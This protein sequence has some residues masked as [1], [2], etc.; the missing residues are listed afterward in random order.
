MN[1]ELALEIEGLLNEAEEL[2]A[3]GDTEG[4][5]EKIAEAKKKIRPIGT[6][7]NGPRPKE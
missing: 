4:A 2:I 1:E 7:T 5:S 6:G 3:Q